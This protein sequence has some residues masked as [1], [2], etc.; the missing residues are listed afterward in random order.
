[1]FVNP[2]YEVLPDDLKLAVFKLGE[3]LYNDA[4]QNRDGVNAYTADV[5]QRVTMYDRLPKVAE[6]ILNSY[7]SM[8]LA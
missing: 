3:K 2:A 7:M 4:T 5:S 6:L 1:V 8:G